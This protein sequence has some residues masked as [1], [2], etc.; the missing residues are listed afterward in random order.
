[1]TQV[2]KKLGFVGI[3]KSLQEAIVDL[4]AQEGDRIFIHGRQS[5]VI[6]GDRIEAFGKKITII[7]V[8]SNAVLDSKNCTNSKFFGLNYLSKVYMEN[9]RIDCS[10]LRETRVFDFLSGELWLRECKIYLGTTHIL[11]TEDS[12]LNVD[13]C[14][15]HSGSSAIRISPFAKRV[16]VTNSKFRYCGEADL[17]GRTSRQQNACI[18]LDGNLGHSA[19]TEEDL[20][21]LI[22]KQNIFEDNMCY[23]IAERARYC[24][25]NKFASEI[26]V[27]I[28]HKDRYL[29]ENNTLKGKNASVMEDVTDLDANK[30]YFNDSEYSA[31]K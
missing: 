27:Y 13:N 5:M 23:P 17:F 3:F 14:E 24:P 30:M 12:I 18:L 25:E 22:C 7:G 26:A 10:H 2:E 11:V 4:A 31:R 20:V 28:A 19:S 6:D 21:K 1:M 16:I 29:L 8:G 9:I 15:F